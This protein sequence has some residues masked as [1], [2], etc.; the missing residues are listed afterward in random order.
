MT[1]FHFLQVKSFSFDHV[2]ILSVSLL[3]SVPN[4]AKFPLTASY[5][6]NLGFLVHHL[7]FI[8]LLQLAGV[9]LFLDLV[10]K[11]FEGFLASIFDLSG[12]LLFLSFYSSDSNLKGLNIVLL[13]DPEP[14]C[15]GGARE[16]SYLT[17]INRSVVSEVAFR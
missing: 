10:S 12:C 5:D 7:V 9:L 11:H 16:R 8:L 2:G 4:G 14:S 3:N 6:L 17:P 15:L 13:L 1:L